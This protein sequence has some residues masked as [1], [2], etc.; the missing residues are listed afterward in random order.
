MDRT[1]KADETVMSRRSAIGAAAALGAGAVFTGKAGASAS[2]AVAAPGW[3]PAKGEYELPPLPYA[4]DALEPFIDEQTMRIHHGTHHQGYVNGLNRALGKLRDIRE[5][6]GDIALIKH[7][8]RE[9]SFHG[10]GH[11]NHAMFWAGM[12][13]ADNGGGGYPDGALAARINRDF[14]TFE[15]FVAH[16]KA[17]SR[18]VEGSGWGWLVHDP[19]SG[20]LLVIQG[21]KQQDMMMTGVVPLLGVDV[22]EHAYYLKYQSRR[23]DYLDAFMNV[24][25][26]A[27][28]GRRY[29]AAVG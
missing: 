1:S 20:R 13:P 5:G 19:V 11:V 8:S 25:N 23:G 29:D 10:S 17:A 27:E 22:W 2:S 7:W 28:I 4:Y 15:Q 24:V 6:S 14:G 12:A 16:F 18:S 9:V 3:N 21:E 26:W